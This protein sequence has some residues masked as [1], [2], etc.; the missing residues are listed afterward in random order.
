MA[1]LPMPVKY[2]S[3]KT[4]RLRVGKQMMAG[5]VVGIVLLNNFVVGRIV[6]TVN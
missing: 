1:M 5:G 4:V 2:I 3:E 6:F